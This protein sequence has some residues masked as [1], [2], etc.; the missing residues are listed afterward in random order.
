MWV[1]GAPS[2]CRASR[3]PGAS[4]TSVV[5]RPQSAAS[6]RALES[7]QGLARSPVLPASAAQWAQLPPVWGKSVHRSPQGS[8]SLRP[9]SSVSPGVGRYKSFGNGEEDPQCQLSQSSPH[10]PHRA[11][12]QRS[13]P[14]RGASKM[15]QIPSSRSGR[16]GPS[17]PTDAGQGHSSRLESPPSEL[18]TPP[19]PP[20]PRRHDST[21]RDRAKSSW[22][23]SV[24]ARYKHDRQPTRCSWQEHGLPAR[25]STAGSWR[26]WPPR[27][28]SRCSDTGPAYALQADGQKP[29][30]GCAQR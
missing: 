21:D 22:A 18:I 23:P 24:A 15:H 13:R 4:Q 3:R 6:P 26:G 7:L 2:C 19:S 10:L 30:A 12:Q 20:G 9:P 17:L 16:Q 11:A 1:P 27:G 14:R 28:W 29:Q 25:S 8:R 5:G